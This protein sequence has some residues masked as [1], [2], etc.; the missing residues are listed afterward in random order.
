MKTP[1]NP[2]WN[3][4]PDIPWGS[5]GWRMGW[6]EDYMRRWAK[7][8][9][10][11]A[12]SERQGYKNGWPEPQE[13]E[14][15]YAFM[16]LGTTPPWVLEEQRKTDAAGGP[17]RPEETAITERYR[18]KWMLTKYLRHVRT[19]H[20]SSDEYYDRTLFEAPNGE[21]WLCYFLKPA[22]VRLVRKPSP[23]SMQ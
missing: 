4:F 13:W 7:W 21:E 3:E 16:E 22:G 18:A 5:A 14:G 10:S 8:Y 9:I 1:M 12:E 2:V 6:G 20:G 19:L 15:F 17:P 11:L 23:E